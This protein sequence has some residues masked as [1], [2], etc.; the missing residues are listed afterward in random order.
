MTTEARRRVRLRFGVYEIDARTGEVWRDGALVH[1]PPQ[2]FKVLWLLAS[3][4]GDVVTREEIR[5][6]LWGTDTFV[7]FDGSLNFCVNQ[8][9]KVL[10]GYRFIA[11]VETIAATSVIAEEPAGEAADPPAVGS[12]PGD[13]DG[14]DDD[15]S[16]RARASHLYEVV[17]EAGG[18]ARRWR[19]STAGV[20]R[21]SASPVAL[22]DEPAEERLDVP[23]RRADPPL[24]VREPPI[25]TATTG[26][27][28]TLPAAPMRAVRRPLLWA[29]VAAVLV[30]VSAIALTRTPRPQPVYERVLILTVG[31]EREVEQRCTVDDRHVSCG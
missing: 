10:R 2:P 12:P 3:R 30:A 16:P 28:A 8:I 9:R 18:D 29:G 6:E 13:P 25:P 14:G 27:A 7:D 31:H 5:Q 21:L 26:A 22:A 17:R 20:V 24:A 1:L 19:P 15:G 4:A 11:S 23:A